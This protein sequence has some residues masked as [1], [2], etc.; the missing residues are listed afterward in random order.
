MTAAGEIRAVRIYFRCSSC[1]VGAYAL[2][3]RLGISGRYSPQAQRLICLAGA[4]WSFDMA[5]ERL[6]EL[7]GLTVSDTTIREISQRHGGLMLSWQRESP[8]AV[9]EFREAQGDLEFTTDGTC[10]NTTGGWREMKLGIFSRRQRGEPAE[11]EDWD[12]RRLPA[13]HV[14]V[15]FAAIEKS[16]RFGSRWK[17]WSRRLGILDPSTVTVLADGAKWIWEEQ[18][19]NL[20]GA[21]GILDVFHALEHVSDAAKRLFGDGTTQAVAWT[22]QARRALL[23][24][25]WEGIEQQLH[26][27]RR[28]LRSPRKRAALRSLDNYLGAHIDHLHYAERLAQGRSIGS[29][30]V[31]GACKNLIGRRLKQTGARWRVRRV[32][33][34]AGLCCLMY[35]HNWNTYWNA[36][37]A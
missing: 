2:D 19:T 1:T 26:E 25:G 10:V 34:M 17:Q 8:Q 37:N 32:N 15:A 30:Q 3:E 13:P 21:E 5:A 7:S 6:E 24:D 31:E 27:T 4:S 20:R 28:L 36:L 23:R 16:Q 22:V 29:G 14:R 18:L 12:T 35:S 11:P 33:R 9:R